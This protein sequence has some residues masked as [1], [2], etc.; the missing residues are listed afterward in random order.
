MKI[1]N[2]F[3]GVGGN[4]ALWGEEHDITSV[5]Y[6]EEI[7][8]IYGKR[9]PNDT[10]IV[11]D[12][13]EYFINNFEKFKILWA[14]PPCQ[15]HSWNTYGLV[16]YAYKGKRRKVQLPDMRLFSLI[17]FCKHQFRGDWVVENV[18]MYYEPPIKPTC[19]RGRHYYWSNVN[20]PNKQKQNGSFGNMGT[21]E[22][23][24]F[25]EKV[26]NDRGIDLTS[27]DSLNDYKRNQMLRNMI[28]PEE[29]KFILDCILNKNKKN[30]FIYEDWL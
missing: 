5:E 28:L 18:K 21:Y 15:S 25:V 23:K 22:S 20:I 12:A 4:R 29:G 2:L 7:A 11:G 16:G 24:E 9:F 3:A 8:E 26:A 19:M 1:L 6:D 10:I 30:E 14:S 17:Y 27:L 13:Y